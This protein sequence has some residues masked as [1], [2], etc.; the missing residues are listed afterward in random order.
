MA[1]DRINNKLAE[2]DLVTVTLDSSTVLGRVQLIEEGRIIKVTGTRN[3]QAAAE[4]MQT[5]KVKVVFDFDFIFDP[6]VGLTNI[7]KVVDPQGE[8]KSGGPR[9]LLS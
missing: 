2:G 6:R 4:Q 9:E 3:P 5:G 8:R 7:I 1:R